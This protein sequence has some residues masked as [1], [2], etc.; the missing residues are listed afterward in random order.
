MT[1]PY[2]DRVSG[3]VL[4]DV[5][6]Q[7]SW[8]DIHCAFMDIVD[9]FSCTSGMTGVSETY[10]W[11]IVFVTVL[12]PIKSR[13]QNMYNNSI[14]VSVIKDSWRQCQSVLLVINVRLIC[15]NIRALY[16]RW[17]TVVSPYGDKVSDLLMF[18]VLYW[19]SWTERYSAFMDMVDMS[20][21][22]SEMSGGRE[23]YN[24]IVVLITFL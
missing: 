20:S 3:V 23:T 6:Y 5:L 24:W 22:T 19:C 15:S 14:V 13:L 2:G 10:S 7:W 16:C 21:C 18:G 8:T 12:Y 11:I 4:F 9:T 17:I 1:S